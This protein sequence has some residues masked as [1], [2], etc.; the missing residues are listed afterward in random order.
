MHGRLPVWTSMAGKRRKTHALVAPYIS[1]S[2]QYALPR[3]LVHQVIHLTSWSNPRRLVPPH[4]SPVGGSPAAQGHQTAPLRWWS[5]QHC[6]RFVEEGNCRAAVLAGD[7]VEA[8][9]MVPS[10]QGHSHLP[11]PPGR[12]HS[13]YGSGCMD[14]QS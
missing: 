1:P 8:S 5:P 10:S 9:P 3:M 2:S 4:A 13:I 11:F 12:E 6:C 14:L 7:W